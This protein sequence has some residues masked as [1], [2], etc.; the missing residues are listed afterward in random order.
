M[1]ERMEDGW[2]QISVLQIGGTPY[3]SK[4]FGRIDG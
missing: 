1:A 2:V 3:C 4:A